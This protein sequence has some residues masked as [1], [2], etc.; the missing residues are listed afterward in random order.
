LITIVAACDAAEFEICWSW[1][2][3]LQVTYGQETTLPT[4]LQV[5]SA[6]RIDVLS[7]RETV[8]DD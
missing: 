7:L 2:S 6:L 4:W 5:G 1:C 3:V 8:G